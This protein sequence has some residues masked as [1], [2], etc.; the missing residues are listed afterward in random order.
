K[1]AGLSNATLSATSTE[2][3]TGQQLFATNSALTTLQG[4]VSTLETTFG[5]LVV[6]NRKAFQG[7]AMGFAATAAPLNLANGESGLA[8]GVGT[9]EGEWA[10]AIRAQAVTSSGFGI[11]ANVG[12]SK[13]AFGAGVGASIKF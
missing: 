6:N 7:V 5:Q 13:D 12:F 8:G 1:I 10:A 9:F 4:R 11:G 3:V 2:A